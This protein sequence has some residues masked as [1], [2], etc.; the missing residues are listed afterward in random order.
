MGT[1]GSRISAGPSCSLY[2]EEAMIELFTGTPG[3]GKSASMM[4][5]MVHHLLDGGIVAM[6]FKLTKNWA[7][8]L[9]KETSWRAR[10]DPEYCRELAK[11]LW[12]RAFY[13]GTAES[14]LQLSALMRKNEGQGLER[15]CSKKKAKLREGMGR[16]FIDEAQLYFNTRNWKENYGFIEFFTQHRKLRWDVTMVAHSEQMIDKQIRSLIEYETA[17]RNLK[18]V[19]ILGLRPFAILPPV[20]WSVQS[21]AGVGPGG[22]SRTSPMADFT[23]LCKAYAGLY[24]SFEVFAFGGLS[25]RIKRQPSGNLFPKRDRAKELKEHEQLGMGAAEVWPRY[26]ERIDPRAVSQVSPVGTP[27]LALNL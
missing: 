1:L 22:G 17:Y 3:S 2:P 19:K 9:A 15:F 25:E 16:L 23:W 5:E 14:C 13:V 8:D 6:N 21:M 11:R 18:N 4:I 12:R 27:S 26:H 24:D 10:H 7:E 20:F